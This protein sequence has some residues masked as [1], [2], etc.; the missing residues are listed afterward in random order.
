M[1]KLWEEMSTID[2]N[3]QCTC[4]CSCMDK[5]KLHNAEQ[6]RRLIYFQMGLNEMYTTARGNILMMSTLLS[7][8]QAFAILCQ[9]DKQREVKPHNHTTLDSTSLNAYGQNNNNTCYK[10]FKTYYSSSKG[11]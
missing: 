10:G 4:L 5:A 2:V 9:E 1:K 11:A 8:A 6:D 3:S 7:M